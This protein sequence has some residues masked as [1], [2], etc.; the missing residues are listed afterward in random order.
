MAILMNNVM[1]NEA[2]K[3]F[4]ANMAMRNG[5]VKAL[6]SKSIVIRK[7]EVAK[8][9]NGEMQVSFK[10]GTIGQNPVAEAFGLDTNVRIN[11]LPVEV[12]DMNDK[13][14]A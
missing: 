13:V 1:N 4:S 8:D 5:V 10:Y 9:D 6:Y 11:N 12:K 14:K 3:G 2:V 7:F